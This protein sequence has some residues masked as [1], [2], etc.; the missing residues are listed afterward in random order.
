MLN[1][2]L[3]LILL[4]IA[5]AVISASEIA[6]IVSNKIKIELRARKKYFMAINAK[7]FVDNSNI[8]FSTILISHNLINIIFATLSYLIFLEVFAFHWAVTLI[9]SA[10]LLLIFGELIP[11]YLGKEF[12]DSFILFSALPVRVIAFFLYPIAKLTSSFSSVLIRTNLK[13]EEEIIHVSDKDDLQNLLEESSEAGKMDETQSD[14]I[15]KVI[16]IRE[17]RVYEAMTPRTELIGVDLTSTM[18]EVLDTF[19]QSGYSKILVYDENLDN[20]NGWLFTKDIFKQ[21]ED[22]KSIIREVLFV[23]ET[24]KSLEMLNEFLRKQISVA[25][26]VDEFGGTAG[27]ITVEDLIEEL[28]GEIR[29]E[30]DDAEEKMIR[31]VQAN[32]F[33]LSGKTEIDLLNEEYELKIPEGDYETIAGFIMYKIGRIPV[34]G[35]SFKIDDFTILILRSDK[36]KID[37]VK[38]TLEQGK[39]E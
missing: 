8:F 32:T 7:Y 3:I 10:L 4:L 21:P 13:E 2:L 20:I 22:W 31:K 39:P 27:L 12:A 19:I 23:P 11:K 34:K 29:D 30:Y 9:I 35:E 18:Q 1:E 16:D 28:F 6:F 36:T 37:L 25:V 5:S 33:V 15:S 14:I 24:K 26:V 38:L 17:Q